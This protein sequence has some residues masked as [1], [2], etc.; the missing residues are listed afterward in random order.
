MADIDPRPREEHRPADVGHWAEVERAFAGALDIPPNARA[1]YVTACST[2]PAV[3]EAVARLL[4]RHDSLEGSAA[5]FLAPLDRARVAQFVADAEVPPASI[6]RYK[7]QRVLGRGAF[8]TVHLA[9]DPELGRDVAIKL[10]AGHLGDGGPWVDRFVAEARAASQLAHPHI[11]TVHDIGRAADGRLFIVMGYEG[12]GTLRDL[13]ARGPLELRA[14]VQCVA[15]VADGLAAAHAAGLVHRDIKPENL[16]ATPRGVR[17]TDFGIAKAAAETPTRRGVVLGTAAYMSPEQ[18]QGLDVDVRA[19]LWSLGVVLYELLTGTRPFTGT[20][21]AETLDDIRRSTPPAPSAR[22]PDIPAVLDAIVLRCLAKDPADRFPSA[23]VLRDALYAVT[24]DLR[25]ETAAD[26]HDTRRLPAATAPVH[27]VRVVRPVVLALG[28]LATVALGWRWTRGGALSAA[29][30]APTLAVLPLTPADT[31]ETDRGLAMTITES[32]RQQLAAIP[33]LRVPS[34]DHT[35][36]ARRTGGTPAEMG[37]RAGATATLTGTIQREGNLVTVQAALIGSGRGDTIWHSRLQRTIGELAAAEQEIVKSVAAALGATARPWRQ[38]DPVAYELYLRGR[39]ALDRWSDSTLEPAAFYFRE[40]IARD[41]GFARAWLGL[42][43]TYTALQS[44][45]PADRFRLAKPLVAR[46]IAAQPD[47]AAAH[48]QAGWIA[49]LY[50]HDWAGAEQHYLRALALDPNEI[51][52]YHGYAALLSATG[53]TDSSLAIT[54]RAMPLDP[55][56]APTTTHLAIH[57]YQRGRYAE[58]IAMLEDLL[59]RDSTSWP[60]AHLVLG[61]NY[62]AVGRY[63]EALQ[64]LRRYAPEYAGLEAR[65]VLA[66]A[67]A[68]SG[69]TA[70]ARAMVDAMEAEARARDL[71]A[72]NLVVA[73]AGLGDTARALDWLER[74][75]DDRG[76]L[77]F[78]LTEP[79]YDRLRGSPRW[80]RVIERLGLTSADTVRRAPAR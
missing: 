39:R 19:D 35:M 8:G 60:R 45:P 1:S 46:A 70:E 6:G 68:V 57:L 58:A 64:L 75:P 31:V 77:L 24:R 44:T 17:I 53:R 18:S 66:H 11:V 25:G 16:L 65:G 80:R 72:V 61:R 52:T 78:L 29:P 13:L 55:R 38:P 33:G 4:E 48:D 63:D 30:T 21:V 22:R 50:D 27:R 26:H 74:V 9:H 76:H 34:L 10:L 36:A 40:A 41:S 14:A 32:L 23:E 71:G 69:R 37:A 59:A 3:R 7:L 67:L 28:V 49:F 15:D 20:S 56:G 5:D 54:R 73:Y 62:L 79:W 43:E 47:L 2:D 12:G 51:W 42:A